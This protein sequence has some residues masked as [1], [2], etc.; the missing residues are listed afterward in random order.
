MRQRQRSFLVVPGT[1]NL[2]ADNREPSPQLFY[3]AGATASSRRQIDSHMLPSP[4]GRERPV[5]FSES[6]DI[7]RRLT[8]RVN[9][10]NIA[11]LAHGG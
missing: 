9:M 7:V 6:G 1:I 8:M 11:C 5:R 4:A 2:P 3:A 10:Q